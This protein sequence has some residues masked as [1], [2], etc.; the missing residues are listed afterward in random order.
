MSSWFGGLLIYMGIIER[1]RITIMDFLINDTIQDRYRN[2]IR[3][4]IIIEIYEEIHLKVIE[5]NRLL[6][7]RVE[8]IIAGVL[9][10]Y[11]E[12][13]S[14]FFLKGKVH[15]DFILFSQGSTS[16]KLEFKF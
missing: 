4:K 14:L 8:E 13:S 12:Y 1:E 10:Q 5:N 16:N 6:L 9:N 2:L 3:T 7:K 11:P 15:R